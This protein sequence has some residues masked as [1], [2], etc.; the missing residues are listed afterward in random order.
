VQGNVEINPAFSAPNSLGTK[1]VS[2]LHRGSKSGTFL[3]SGFLQQFFVL[4]S[5]EGMNPLYLLHL[6]ITENSRS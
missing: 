1:F 2:W 4:F 3:C 6:E 5:I